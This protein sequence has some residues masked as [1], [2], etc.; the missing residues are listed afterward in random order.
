MFQILSYEE[1]LLQ[2]L[3]MCLEIVFVFK[4]QSDT[5]QLWVVWNEFEGVDS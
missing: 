2:W 3:E 4:S 1:W 5:K